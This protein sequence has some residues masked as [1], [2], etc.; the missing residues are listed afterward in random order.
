MIVMFRKMLVV[1][2]I[3]FFEGEGTA[4]YRPMFGLWLMGGFLVLNIFAKPFM[5]S[6]LWAL[7]NLS[8]GCISLSLNLSMM[9]NEE[10]ELKGTGETM[11][12]L[13]IL[14]INLSTMLT[15]AYVLV[16]DAGKETLYDTFDPDNTGDLSWQDIVYVA[17]VKAYTS[18]SPIMNK[19]GLKMK[20][21]DDDADIPPE[22]EEGAATT[23]D[24]TKRFRDLRKQR[25]YE[26]AIRKFELLGDGE[27]MEEMQAE[28]EQEVAERQH[29]RVQGVPEIKGEA[30]S[31]PAT[32]A[33][34]AR[35]ETAKPALTSKF[36]FTNFFKKPPAAAHNEP[37]PE[38]EVMDKAKGGVEDNAP[39]PMTRPSPQ[40]VPQ[41]APQPVPAAPQAMPAS[42]SPVVSPAAVPAVPLTKEQKN[43]KESA[44]RNKDLFGDD[45][46]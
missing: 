35:A 33:A 17:R 34:T 39:S 2:I 20:N 30:L 28:L 6:R 15:F 27:K 21:P 13:A 24:T 23:Y 42:V 31:R 16:F 7:E 41:A 4:Q 36:S 9:Y 29:G 38:P 3:V 10:Y 40:P 14:A 8:L 26:L 32:R 19:M 43:A 12:T 44:A 18:L 25:D 45:S 11:V 22:G 5:Y 1:F 46:D 37:E